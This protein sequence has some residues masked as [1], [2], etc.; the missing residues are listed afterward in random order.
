MI[1]VGVTKGSLEAIK[2]VFDKSA[3][4][5]KMSELLERLAYIGVKD[6]SIRFAQSYTPGEPVDC[7]AEPTKNGWKIVAEGKD[8][9][10]IEFGAG[11]YYNGTEPYP[12][13]RPN[14][15]SNIGEFGKGRGKQEGWWYGDHQYT[16]G[17][18][19][20]MPMYHASK[21]ILDSIETIANEVFND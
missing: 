21:E 2:K 7:H 11:V 10:F 17:T 12:I 19:A 20:A 13:S 3:L 4:D 16:H 15:I 8:V 6:A 14:G 18:P 1:R 5:K 9:C